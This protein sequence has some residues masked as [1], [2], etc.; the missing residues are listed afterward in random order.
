M[1]CIL[2]KDRVGDAGLPVEM[3]EVVVAA[4]YG[5]HELDPRNVRA[6]L[7]RECQ[8]DDFTHTAWVQQGKAPDIVRAPVM[9]NENRIVIP[10]M[11]KQTD[12]VTGEACDVI[13]RDRVRTGGVP[14]T[15]LVRN[16]DVIPRF[17]KGRYLMPPRI[18]VFRPAVTKNDWIARILSSSLK[19]L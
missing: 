6:G 4:K 13:V 9:P 3:N 7:I 1:L 14:K 18:G 17:D 15:P 11:I 10:E 2:V 8:I 19:Y 12:K 16:D 5:F